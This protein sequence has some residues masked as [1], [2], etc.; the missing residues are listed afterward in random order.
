MP[1]LQSARAVEHRLLVVDDEPLVLRSIERLLSRSGPGW[2]LRCAHSG[3]EAIKLL[4][5]NCF[6]VIISD[7]Q[8]PKMSGTELLSY[9]QMRY[10][11]MVRVVLTGLGSAE[12][13]F[14]SAPT[15]HQYL[16]KPFDPDQFV[17]GVERALQ[18]R[19]L[20]RNRHIRKIV[21][22]SNRLPPVPRMYSELTR[23]LASPE[24]CIDDVAKV[25]S[26]DPA[27]CAQVLRLI[28]SPFF[29]L[30]RKVRTIYEA[31]GLLGFEL[32]KA[33][34]LCSEIIELY[35]G[36]QHPAGFDASAFQQRAVLTSELARTIAPAALRDE[37]I[38][39]GLL[40]DIGELVIASR[41]PAAFEK[42]NAQVSSGQASR[43]E[44][45][46][47]ELEANHAE[48]GAYV[49]GLW[50]LPENIIFGVLHHHDEPET[51][52]RHSS[53]PVITHLASRVSEN[54][55][56]TVYSK[57]GSLSPPSGAA[58]ASGIS[59]KLLDGLRDKARS[60]Q[61]QLL[62]PEPH[63]GSNAAAGG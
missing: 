29:G 16:T 36:E 23:C 10:P 2:S 24:A 15:A 1:H 41:A 43:V 22:T 6:D 49:L 54:P 44:A 42:I 17:A 8:M 63:S 28:N 59:P 3:R 38:T 47:R 13:I 56:A 48:V 19:R 52:G 34:V 55:E 31:V 32:I 40:V 45:E 27:L 58:D 25:V 35:H 51:L 18:L 7:L 26:T 53:L 37:A 62:G 11:E 30:S 5:S 14:R 60:F 61:A 50:G 46:R 20:L 21:G 12:W 9:A 57:D 39:A 33:A 4:E